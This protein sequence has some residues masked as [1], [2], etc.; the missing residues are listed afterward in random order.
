M[1]WTNPAC[2]EQRGRLKDCS[3]GLS[4]DGQSRDMNMGGEILIMSLN[5]ENLKEEV[6][7]RRDDES[8]PDYLLAV[9]EAA[10]RRL[11]MLNEIFGPHSPELLARGG[12][13]QGMRV[14]DIGC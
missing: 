11:L 6:T 8:G 3:S 13:I 5:Q 12:L 9:G 1:T 4:R 10:A 14:A 2:Q 7:E